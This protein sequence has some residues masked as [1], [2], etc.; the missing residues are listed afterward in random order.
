MGTRHRNAEETQSVVEEL[1]LAVWEVG[2]G[3][4]R[5]QCEE[6]G[7]GAKGVMPPPRRRAVLSSSPWD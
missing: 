3:E 5:L 2:E 1:V 7:A 6:R 4:G